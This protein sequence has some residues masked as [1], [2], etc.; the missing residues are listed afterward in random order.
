[1]ARIPLR[2]GVFLAPF[3][4]MDENPTACLERDLELMAWLDRLGFHEAWIGEHHSAGWEIIS[5]PELFIAIAAERTRHLR[6]GTGVVSLPYHNPLMVANRII[7]LDHHTRG[8]VMFG[9]GPGLLAS[10]AL[11]LGIDPATQRDRMA[12]ALDVILRLFRGETVTEKT[13]WYTFVNARAQLP[14]YTKPHPEIA[15]ASAVT[16]SGGRLAGKYGFS[17]ICVAATNPF[18]YD[19]LAANWQ[20]A[21]E[22][23]AEDGRTMDPATL[24]LVGPMHIAET[25]EQAMKNVK[26]GF[27]KYI[28]YFNNNQQRFNVPPGQDPAEWFV[29]NKFGVIGTPDDAIAMIE[30]LY[31]KQGEFGVYLQQANNVADWEATKRSYELYARFVMPHFSGDNGPRIA[32]F[33]WCT[34]NRGDLAE[35]RSKAAAAMFD[36]HE[37]EQRARHEATAMARPEKGREAW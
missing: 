33:D 27:A 15:V 23:A 2:H 35:K 16:P 13:D 14:P 17:M 1:M 21:N 37:T 6:F 26:F 5:S 7:Q 19:A 22:I 4:A 8:R 29:E 18:G 3:H 34:A 10:D 31:E 36:K 28:D 24:R 12:E 25:R 11:M 32:S 20:I 30:R 9:A